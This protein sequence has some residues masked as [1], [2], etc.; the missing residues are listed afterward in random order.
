[1]ITGQ[2]QQN[3]RQRSTSPFQPGKRYAK[4]VEKIL[5]STLAG[6]YLMITVEQMDEIVRFDLNKRTMPGTVFV[7]TY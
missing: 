2:T 1:M 3:A 5:Q 7:E 6:H 4:N